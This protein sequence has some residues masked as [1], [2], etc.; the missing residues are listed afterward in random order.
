MPIL[1]NIDRALKKEKEIKGI[2]IRKEEIKLFQFADGM[3]LYVQHPQ[4]STKKLLEL[5]NDISNYARYKIN[6]QKSVLFLYTRATNNKKEIKK[7][8]PNNS[9]EC[10]VQHS[11]YS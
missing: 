7:T 10:C 6:T 4:E 9:W 5:I 2:H 11:D 1:S 3:I 8:I